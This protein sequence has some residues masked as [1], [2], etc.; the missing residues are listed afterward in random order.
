[1]MEDGRFFIVGKVVL[2]D[3]QCTSH[4]LQC[5]SHDLKCRFHDLK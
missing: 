2:H 4:D 3:L 5:T 1:M